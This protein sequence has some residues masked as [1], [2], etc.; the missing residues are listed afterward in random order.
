MVDAQATYTLEHR[1]KF[2][3]YRACSCAGVSRD[4]RA[5][6]ACTPTDSL[7]ADFDQ[8]YLDEPEEA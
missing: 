8:T 5:V 4:G 7:K 3:I 2:Y 1:G 6:A